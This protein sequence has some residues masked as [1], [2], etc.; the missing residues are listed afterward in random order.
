MLKYIKLG[1]AKLP[2]TVVRFD[3]PTHVCGERC[4]KCYAHKAEKMWPAVVAHRE[5]NLKLAE[6]KDFVKTI[7]KELQLSG[8]PYCRPHCSGDF[9]SQGYVD[10]WVKVMKSNPDMRFFLMSKKLQHFN[11]S[12]MYE[13][14]NVNII[15]SNTPIG[16]NY[17]KEDHIEELKTLGYFECP[18]KNHEVCFRS[19]KACLKIDKVCFKLH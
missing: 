16:L 18:D 2:T 9:Y 8:V 3:L 11:F 19:C 12:K 14:D 1:N 7:N 10:K 13:L 4:F 17:G 6:S 5:N 15:D